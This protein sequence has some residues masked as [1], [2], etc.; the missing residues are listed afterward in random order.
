MLACGPHLYLLPRRHSKDELHQ[1]HHIHPPGLHTLGLRSDV[2]RLRARRE[3]DDDR[4]L[5]AL[6]R[7]R[8]RGGAGGRSPLPVLALEALRGL[9]LS[10]WRSARIARWII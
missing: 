7:L 3:L 2:L 9:A 4:R 5:P 6:P 1:V 10:A 8:R